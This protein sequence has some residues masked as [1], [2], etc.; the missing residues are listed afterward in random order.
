MKTLAKWRSTI[1]KYLGYVL[2]ALMGLMVID[3]VWGVV[4][5]YLMGSPSSF[6]GELAGYLLIWVGLLGAALASGKGMHLSIDLLPDRLNPENRRKLDIVIQ[7]LI[8]L[9]AL[10]VLVIGGIRLVYVTLSLGQQSP[11]LN[12]P[13]GYVYTVLPISGFFIMY[14]ATVDIYDRVISETSPQQQEQS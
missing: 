10:G 3:V 1:D 2:V 11:S 8:F 6:T 12:I 14:Y 4:T 5:R 13:L 7:V 9:F